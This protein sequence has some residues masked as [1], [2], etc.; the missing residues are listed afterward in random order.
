MRG[1]GIS[2]IW[3]LRV[4]LAVGFCLSLSSSVSGVT[5][6]LTITEKAGITTTNYPI[7]LGRP[8]VQGEIANYPQV[9]VNGSAVMTQA[10]VKQR[11]ADGSVKHAVIAFLIPTLTA[12]STVTITFQNQASGNNTA[13]T[14]AQMQNSAYDFGAQMQFTNGSTLTADARTMLNAGAYTLWTSGSVAQTIILADHSLSRAYDIGFDSYKAIRPIVHATFWPTIDKVFVRFISEIADTENL[15]DQTYSLALTTGNA[16]PQKVYTKGSFTQSANTRWTKTLWIGGAPSAIAIN[17]NLTYLESTLFTYYYDTSITLQSS[18]IATVCNNWNNVSKDIGGAGLWTI[19]MGTT[20]GRP[21]IGPYTEWVVDYLYS[22]DSCLQAA[23]FGQAD[24]AAS[25]PYHYREGKAGKNLLRTD[26]LGAGTGVGHIMS[27]S[28]RP[29]VTTTVSGASQNPSDA[30]TYVGSTSPNWGS[31]Q[32]WT[33]DTPHVPDVASLQY[34]ISGDFWYLEEMWFLCSMDAAS[35][36]FNAYHRGPTGA[37]GVF[38]RSQI[39]GVAW[40]L[41]NRVNTAF[42]TPDGLPEKTYFETLINDGIANQEGVLNITSTQFKGNAIWNWGAAARS[43]DACTLFP[44]DGTLSPLH[45]F[46]A[47]CPALLDNDIDSSVAGWAASMFEEDYLL[48]ALGRGKELGYPTSAILSYV[49]YLYTGMLTDSGFNHFMVDNERMPTKRLS[50][51]NFFDTFGNMATGFISS[52]QTETSFP[53]ISDPD[54]YPANVSAGVSYITNEPNGAAAWS[55]M[56][57]NWLHNPNAPVNTNPKWAII[58]RPGGG[59]S[60]GANVPPHPPSDL[61]AVVQ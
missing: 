24:L 2:K 49:A 59:T 21:D 34:I 55:F 60:T 52:Y 26:N 50:D 57:T 44:P 1:K 29:T 19:A 45:L 42:I 32:G 48:V 11:W 30:P 23:A 6:S 16:N 46:N 41:R 7:Q 61:R 47:G 20:G 54:G 10:D 22:G 35:N 58:P 43:G 36:Y 12:N 33:Y 56:Q 25:W 3:G 37:E 27:L 38:N 14:L 4:A 31:T 40:E 15:E 39:R 5:N 17:P 28:N 8:F 53:H 9:L 13:L 51:G 18:A